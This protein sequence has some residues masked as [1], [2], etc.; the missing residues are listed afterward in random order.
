MVAV[1]TYVRSTML[2]VW[3]GDPEHSRLR[4]AANGQIWAPTQPH[5]VNR[6]K[7]RNGR[8]VRRI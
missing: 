1:T 2:S 7:H 6:S 8:V 3:L 5:Q 4:T